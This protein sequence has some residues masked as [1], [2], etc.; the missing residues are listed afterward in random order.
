MC[1][2]APR[3]HAL[4]AAALPML[5]LLLALGS[6]HEAWAGPPEYTPLVPIPEPKD[7]VQLS[8]VYVRAGET[9]TLESLVSDVHQ[10]AIAPDRPAILPADGLSAVEFHFFGAP[11]WLNRIETWSD[12][13]SFEVEVL[14]MDETWRKFGTGP[15]ET[16]PDGRVLVL[17]PDTYARG[18]RFRPTEAGDA[19]GKVRLFDVSASFVSIDPDGARLGT[20]GS[21]FV[22]HGNW[23]NQYPGAGNDLSVC[24]NDENSL[25]ADL[26]AADDVWDTNTHG[27]YNSWEEHFKR[28][29]LGGTNSDHVDIADLAYF[30]GHGSHTTDDYWGGDRRTIFFGDSDHDSQHLEPGE[31]RHAWGNGELEWVGLSA[32]KPMVD[33]DLWYHAM[34]GAHLVLG[35]RTNMK[36]VNFGNYFGGYMV[37]KGAHDSAKKI[38]TS[39]WDAA[40]ETHGWDYKAYIVGETEAMGNDYLWG[41]GSVNAD[42]THN[43]YYHWWSYET[44]G[45]PC[46]G[47][48]EEFATPGFLPPTLGAGWPGTAP[49]DP[50]V[51][52]SPNGGGIPVT[53]DRALLDQPA[54]TSMPIYNVI[55]AVVDTPRVR[56]MANRICQ[57][58]GVLCQGDIGPGDS[59]EMNLIDGAYEL[60][61]CSHTGAVRYE[62]TGKWLNWLTSP[63]QLPD[64]SQV[65]AR[66]E[67]TLQAWGMRP[68]DAMVARVD[69]IMQGGR[70]DD[71][72]GM[73]HDDPAFTYG[74]AKRVD[75]TRMLG[76]FPV[77]GP[78]G[79]MSVTIGPNA[80]IQR[81]FQGAW[82]PL[83][84]G[85]A[86]NT[87]PLT[88]VLQALSTRGS[89]ATVDGINPIVYSIQVDS[90][91]LGYYEYGCG[92]LQ[93]SVRPIY[94]LNCTMSETPT[95]QT[96]QVTT[97]DQIRMWAEALPPTGMILSPPDG[98]CIPPG[99]QVCLSGSATGGV[100]PLQISWEDDLGNLLGT[101][102]NLC[103]NLS[104]P[105][106]GHTVDDTTRTVE[107]TVTDALGHV[108]HAAIR[109]CLR[110]GL[111]DA[112]TLQVDAGPLLRSA[113]PN[114]ALGT[115]AFA[116]ELSQAGRCRL[117]IYD[118][119]GRLVA[120]PLD[121]IRDAGA[122]RVRWDGL[123][124]GGS[125][126]ASGV[127]FA[128][129]S[130]LG[131]MS[132][133]S[134][135]LQR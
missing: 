84:Q 3:L 97:Q 15:R 90:W 108:G 24:D 28:E 110:G 30:V 78:G 89:D 51:I 98:T 62:D 85:P 6:P 83:V 44:C 91:Q 58:E 95:G 80:Q 64:G 18:L 118:A 16:R 10:D 115:T 45:F 19:S 71:E 125:P 123:E 129:L 68:P 60:R 47:S 55:P 56:L 117:E 121:A 102:P 132:S 113:Y 126:A 40:E 120:V 114:P 52:S 111:V 32:C 36:D 21:S 9:G 103:A 134:F 37:D 39:W 122:Q 41:E 105:P 53:I 7:R 69:K 116:F 57:T 25:V 135:V 8:R 76:S 65:V 26:D 75:Y 131:R 63:P 12:A 66:A 107:M 49:T 88:S 128:R 13:K 29:D 17:G 27:N 59:F 124:S 34:D 77:V 79:N 48:A 54:G 106:A 50:I 99:G 42:P 109:I 46:I 67:N 94:I 2:C 5:L 1:F 82:R 14:D 133:L 127:Y 96:P 20:L 38:K 87:I 4:S 119:R 74:I 33:C 35:W 93:S 72:S 101:G 130:S 73:A 104:L 61:V 86:V 23:A 22:Y 112:G 81:V 100:A 92:T 11:R 70:V 31:A 43:G